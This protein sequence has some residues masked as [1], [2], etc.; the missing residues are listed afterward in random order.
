M[1]QVTIHLRPGESDRQLQRAVQ[2]LDP[3]AQVILVTGRHGRTGVRVCAALAARYLAT[4][5]PPEP[6]EAPLVVTISPEDEPVTVGSAVVAET[7]FENP[8]PVEPNP[9]VV[10]KPARPAKKAAAAKAPK[11]TEEV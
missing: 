4:L 1:R 2:A 6:V 3:Q 8:E 10:E 11:K 7:V 5:Y 9:V